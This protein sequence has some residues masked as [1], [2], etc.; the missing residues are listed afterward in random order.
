M[1]LSKKWVNNLTFFLMF[2]KAYAQKNKSTY[3]G[4]LNG[5]PTVDDATLF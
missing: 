3:I 1:L 5:I 4:F 2:L